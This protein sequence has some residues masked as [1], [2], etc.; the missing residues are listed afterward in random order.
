[1]PRYILRRI[2]QA[3]P[4]LLGI[5][6]INFTL[7]HLAPGDPIYLLAGDAG[8][9]AYFAAMRAKFGLDQPIPTQLGLYLLNAAQGQF[10]YSFAYTRPVFEVIWSRVP[11]TLLLMG[12]SL[13]LSTA[14]GI[15]MGIVS[16]RRA[17]SALDVGIS[18]GTLLG[19]G[20]PAFWLA[21]LLV[22]VFA[23]WLGWFPIQGMVNVRADHTGLAFVAD[24]LHHLFLPML[25][26]T[27]LHLA[28]V[29][30]LTRTGLREELSEDYVRTAYAKGL[31]DAQVIHRHALRNALLP[32]VTAVGS[33]IPSLFT[34]AVLTEIIFAWPGIGRLLYDA[35]LNRDYPLLMGIFLLVA[36]TVILA[37]LVTDILYTFLDP[38]VRYS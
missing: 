18:V 22:L 7:I 8:D 23:I 10:G 26:L 27:L 25:T 30:R 17:H 20:M 11:A 14:L 19:Y 38:R 31:F 16:A 3:V 4:L 13:I 21:Q 37:N 2:L 28:L 36:V 15:W 5:L 6:I 24:V 33:H 34:G 1:M 9:A 35:T 29:A 12:G 32:V